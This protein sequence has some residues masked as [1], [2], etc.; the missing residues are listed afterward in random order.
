[1][2]SM[3]NW[4]S[5]EIRSIWSAFPLFLSTFVLNGCAKMPSANKLCTKRRLKTN[6][7]RSLISFA[8]QGHFYAHAILCAF[9]C[10]YQKFREILEKIHRNLGS[11]R[12]ETLS[13]QSIGAFN[14]F[15]YCVLCICWEFYCTSTGTMHWNGLKFIIFK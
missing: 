6:A 7:R 11:F 15:R 3:K 13:I 4:R 2:K 10:I 12:I 9:L 8:F 14:C 1:M 5:N